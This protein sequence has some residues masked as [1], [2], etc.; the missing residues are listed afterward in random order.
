MKNWWLYHGHLPWVNENLRKMKLTVIFLCISAVTSL[1]SVGYAQSTRLTVVMKNAKVINIL[2]EIEN[3]SEFKFFFSND[4]DVER[5]AT[6]EKKNADVFEILDVLFKGTNIKYEVYD[7]QIALLEKS[8]SYD[9]RDFAEFQNQPAQQRAISGR[10]TDTSGQ[11]LPGVTIVIKGTTQGTITDI[12]G[13]YSLINVPPDATLVFSFVG[14]QTREVAISNQ[15][16]IDIIMEE[17]TIGLDEVVAIGYGVK[18]KGQLTGSVANVGGEKLTQIRTSD[19]TKSL[20]GVMPGLIINDRGGMPGSED[21]EILI[22]GTHT[23]GDNSPLFVIDGVPRS[24]FGQLSPDDIE[25]I[26]VLKDASA[27]IYGARAANGVIIVRTKRGK[28][29]E[30]RLNLNSDYGVNTLTRLPELMDS[31]QWAVYQNEVEEGYGRV[32]RYSEEDIQKYKSGSHPLTHPNTDFYAATFREFAPQTH[33]NLSASGGAE[34]IKYF[35]SGD[36]LGKESQY[37]SRDGKYNQYQLRSNIDAQVHKYLN[38]GM[39][40]NLRLQDEKMPSEPIS[41]IIHRVWFN[42]PI[43]HAFYPNGLPYYTRE[44]GGNPVVTNS[45]DIGWNEAIDKIIQTKLSFD[46]NLDW[47][48]E[49]LGIIGYAA[50][51][52]D[53]MNNTTHMKPVTLYRYNQNTQEYDPMMNTVPSDGN[54]SLSKRNNVS[55][56]DLYH[57]RVTYDHTFGDHNISAFA[58]YEQ[59]ESEYEYIYAYRKNLFSASKV[60]LF[61]GEEDGRIVNGSS[62]V[63]GRVNYFGYLSYDYMRKYMIDFTIRHDGSFN[64]PKNKRFGTF[65]AVTAGWNISKEP[66][67]S[68][69]TGLIDNLKLRISYG[70]MGNDRIPGYQYLTKYG[71]LAMSNWYNVFITGLDPVYN[72]GMDITNVPNSNITWEISKTMNYGFDADFWK[73]KLSLSFDY[74]NEK[75]RGILIQRN[76]SVPDYT[77]LELPDENLGKVDNSGVEIVASHNNSFGDILYNIG[78]NFTF[79]RS[80]IIFMDEPKDIPD[81]RQKEGHPVNSIVAYNA[82][83]IFNDWEEVNSYPHLSG[84]QPGDIKYIDMNDDGKIDDA[85]LVRHYTSTT[86]EIQFGLTAG[87]QYKGIGLN[88][89]F[90][91]QAN[92]TAPLMFNDSGTKPEYLF[93]GRWTEENKDASHPRP[94][95]GFDGYQRLSTYHFNNASYIRLKNLELSYDLCSAGLIS[96]NLFK[97]FRIYLRGRNLWTLDY[98]KYFD[99]EVPFNASETTRGNRAKYYPQTIT[100]SVGVNITM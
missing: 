45:F 49:G 83:G 35:I 52:Y 69:I 86:P 19:L 14:M 25:D 10:V 17:E 11:P 96:D 76:E 84:A 9:F 50:Y 55:R 40:L 2:N 99:P 21:V 38:I 43:E 60:E 58:A 32:P 28:S 61:A 94:F 93:T 77:A 81:Y 6:I 44:G 82:D 36:Y 88:A 95:A 3:Q 42:Y 4:V 39:D 54:V 15:N 71:L 98:L 16:S 46:L 67:M 74:F 97:Q 59:S 37:S 53:I 41:N 29:G 90:Q 57:V 13:K 87:I 26:S 47:V 72:A 18:E 34:N 48:T 73:G 91:G 31:W 65:P 1:A 63:G 68:G 85:D 56:N 80:K 89:L 62:S 24:G 27:A 66:F 30:L 51:D 5:T 23:L 7:R 22:R 70:E 75:R 100:Y 8:D 20:Q 92:A 64:F 33:H 79:N 12:D 78:G